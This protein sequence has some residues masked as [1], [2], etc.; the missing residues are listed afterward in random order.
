MRF[1]K[2][3]CSVDFSPGS[4]EALRLAVEMCGADSELVIV[5]VWQPLFY[6]YG[7]ESMLTGDITRQIQADAERGLA[8]SKREAEHLG[9]RRVTTLFQTGA[10]W[11]EIVDV[12][13]QDRT[14]ELAVIGSHGR[15]GLAR[16]LLGS[17]AEKVVRHAPCP[18]LVA[19]IRSTEK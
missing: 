5:H 8:E 18:V 19:R 11:R 6:T 13:E 10:P 3:L 7:A 2:I 14:F 16:V 12:L 17:V 1:Q 15:T 9:A 4:S